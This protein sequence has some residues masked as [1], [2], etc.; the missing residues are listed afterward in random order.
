[1]SMP[2]RTMLAWWM[3]R[4]QVAPI[5]HVAVLALESPPRR[6][7][8]A[9]LRVGIFEGLAVERQAVDAELVAARAEL[10]AQECRRAGDAIVREAVAR[11]AVGRRAAP[12]RRTEM[13]VAAHVAARADD[14][15]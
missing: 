9:P 8:P 14:A 6:G 10:R 1:M 11:G 13:L 12:A 3:P 7:A 2:Q 4:P 15:A 5:R